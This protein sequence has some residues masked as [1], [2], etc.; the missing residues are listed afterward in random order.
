[1]AAGG[2]KT[3][4]ELAMECVKGAFA[5]LDDGC[6]AAVV[7]DETVRVMEAESGVPFKQEPVNVQYAF[8]NGSALGL[9]R[10]RIPLVYGEVRHEM[11]VDVVK[12]CLPLL[13]GRRDQVAMR[14]KVDHGEGEVGF[15]TDVG[16]LVKVPLTES[17]SGHWM[18]PLRWD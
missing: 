18:I 15:P 10:I 2:L 12:G 13:L 1:M 5:V 11:L 6:S 3:L 17:G 4:R 7:G 9:Y 14:A 8:G 16:G